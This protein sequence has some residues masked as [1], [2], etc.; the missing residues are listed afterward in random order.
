MLGIQ[1]DMKSKHRY[2]DLMRNDELNEIYNFVRMVDRLKSETSAVSRRKNHAPTREFTCISVLL[3]T[4][5]H[6]HLL[7]T[8]YSSDLVILT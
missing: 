8:K 1:E 3:S 6:F 4:S 5:M 7:S 2:Q